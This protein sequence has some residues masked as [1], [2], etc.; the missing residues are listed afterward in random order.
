MIKIENRS[1]VSTSVV[2]CDGCGD[3]IHENEIAAAAVETVCESNGTARVE[4]RHED[5]ASGATRIKTPPGTATPATGAGVS[6]HVRLDSLRS[7]FDEGP[8]LTLAKALDLMH[9]LLF[10]LAQ[11]HDSRIIHRNLHP[12]C[13]LV[14]A[15]GNVTIT[16]FGLAV[17]P[18]LP[19]AGNRGELSGAVVTMSPE[20]IQGTGCDARSDI[21][22]AGV[23]FYQMLTGEPPFAA[24]GAWS[25]AKKILSED[26]APP[27]SVNP[28][29]PPLL[30]GVV[31]R[32]L[33]KD[34]SQ[35]YERAAEFAWA[36]VRAVPELHP[37]IM[38]RANALKRLATKLAR[39][40]VWA[41]RGLHARW[42]RAFRR[43]PK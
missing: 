1:G 9:G 10:E 35:R 13:I 14:D 30:D 29:I 34:P 18:G 27:S 43:P 37:P 16:G 20:Q 28:A 31:L 36:I 40:W 32:A 21:F 24:L 42:S 12:G 4:H 17:G 7:W 41:S 2:L 39:A 6:V 22:Q 5:C 38:R 8:R 11:I 26:P 3:V 25:S 15:A 23:I 19:H 33:A